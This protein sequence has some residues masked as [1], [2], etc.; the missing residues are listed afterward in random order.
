MVK[1]GSKFIGDER[2]ELASREAFVADDDL[3]G[4]DEVAGVAEHRFGCFPFSDLR[5]PE[6][7]R[8]RPSRR[9]PS[10]LSRNPEKNREWEAQY[11]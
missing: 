2:F 10:R 8:R 3:P 7:P 1:V 5:V 6:P 9:G 11:P 4:L